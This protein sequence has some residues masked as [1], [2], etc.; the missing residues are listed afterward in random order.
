MN[1]AVLRLLMAR[2][3]QATFSARSADLDTM[4]RFTA[5]LML[6]IG[7]MFSGIKWNPI[8]GKMAGFGCLTCAGFTAYSKFTADAAV[9]VPNLF[10]VYSAILLLGGVNIMFFP[11]NAV[12]PK[13]AEMKSK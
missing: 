8:N 12:V 5:C 2:R 3:L 13:G 1:C 6:T 10:Y 9:F 11:S 4:V 7:F